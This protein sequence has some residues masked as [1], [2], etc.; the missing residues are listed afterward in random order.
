[1]LSGEDF[2]QIA[3]D[4]SLDGYTLENNGDLGWRPEGIVNGLLLT[5]VLEEYVF[6]YPVGEVVVPVR[7]AEKTKDLGYWLIEVLERNEETEEAH[8][9]AMILTSEEEAQTVLQR[10]QE[11]DDFTELA[12]EYSQSWSEEDG[13]DLGW[14]AAGDVSEAFSDFVF[15]TETELGI[16][17]EPIRD[18]DISTEGGYWLFKIPDSGI[19]EISDEDR[20]LLIQQAIQGWLELLLENPENIVVSYLDDEMRE[21]AISKFSES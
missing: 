19:R 9:Q 13:A 17:S 14:L 3:G 2:G 10:L 21:F 8:V 1:L 7:D 5:S 12:E 15:N 4:L 18:E 20:D 16:F 6:S 11:D